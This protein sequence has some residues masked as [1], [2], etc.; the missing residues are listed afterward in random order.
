MGHETGQ[1]QFYPDYDEME[2]Y[3]GVLRPDNLAT[4][5][6]RAE[7]AGV[8]RKAKD[9]FNAAGKWAAKL[10]KADME[11]NLRTPGMGGFQLLDLQ[12]YPGQGTALVG[13]L[14]AFL[15]SKGLMT[16]EEWKEAC[17]D[18]TVLANLPS[19]T[20]TSGDFVEIPLEIVDYSNRNLGEMTIDW[21]L[22]FVSG[23]ISGTVKKGVNKI[24]KIATTIPYLRKPAKMTLSLSTDNGAVTN[25]YDIW[26]YPKEKKEV[27]NVF[28]TRSIDEALNLLKEGKRVILYPDS[29][30][31]AKATIGPLFQTD[32]WNYRMFLTIAE[33]VNKK[34]SPGTM[35]LLIDDSHPLFANYPTD[36]HTDW[37]W[38]PVV[39]NSFPLVI[40]RLPDSVDPIVAPIDNIERNY[41]LALMLEAFVGKGRLLVIMAD[42]D[43]AAEHPEGE[44]LMQAAK[45]YVASKKFKPQ[46]SLTPR[47]L[48][49]LLTRP[50][51]ARRLNELNNISY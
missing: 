12:D 8:L 20:F 9:Y 17:S 16:A 27:K 11:M 50:S 21:K 24:G 43:K 33:K 28:V 42:M 23:S 36:S 35:G 51:T 47:Q 10:Y 22:P 26:I 31:V 1:Y 46:L 29:A 41:R 3:T 39:S 44:W 45:E 19:Y 13:V 7:E 6:K 37:Q 30:E 48:R 14:D 4:F 5:K 25:S 49:A 38:F 40:D 15:D 34:P 2:K 18:L 32:Y